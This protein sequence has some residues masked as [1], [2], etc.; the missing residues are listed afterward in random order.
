M[1]EPDTMPC[2][3]WRRREKGKMQIE[4]DNLT[5]QE[6]IDWEYFL[7]WYNDNGWVGDDARRLAWTDLQKKYQRLQEFSDV[8]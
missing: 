6:R 7:K 3:G 4:L 1:N 8:T 5:A 2:G